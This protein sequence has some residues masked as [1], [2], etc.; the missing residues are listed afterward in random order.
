MSPEARVWARKT[1][2][3]CCLLGTS[4][5]DKGKFRS[6]GPGLEFGLTW[7][8]AQA[9]EERFGR[10]FV[11]TGHLGQSGAACGGGLHELAEE[12]RSPQSA[13]QIHHCLVRS[14]RRQTGIARARGAGLKEN[15][16]Q[17]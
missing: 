10:T 2:I 5:E 3:S 17:H 6:T 15:P 4:Q 14:S 16:Y 8:E 12:D 1:R 11:A 7:Q 9:E 13:S